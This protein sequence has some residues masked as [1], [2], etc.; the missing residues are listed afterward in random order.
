M[1]ADAMQVYRG[2]DT[3]TA[4]PTLE[5]R[6]RVPHFLVDIADPEEDFSA[7]DYVRAAERALQSV[8]S[9]GLRPMMVGG[10]GLYVRAFLKGLFQGPARVESLRKRL[11]RSA[12]RG[13][14]GHLHRMLAR[15]DPPT[16]ARLMP[17]DSQKI[18]R[19]LE[20]RFATRR[21]L[22]AH[23]TGSFHG[24]WRGCDRFPVVKVGLKMN[25]RMLWERI[26]KRVRTFF[27]QGLVD[28][29]RGL[30]ARGV[31][32]A[33]NAFKGIGYRQCLAVIR[34]R[35][36]E[37][38]AMQRTMVATRQYARRQMTWF[39]REEGTHWLEASADPL[40]TLSSAEALLY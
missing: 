28:E 31:P 12:R 24:D 13:G 8:R 15:L 30:L 25:R 5:D 2:F 29:V 23:L 1:S 27:A 6:E 37:T 39:R 11:R 22:S 40:E 7:G 3:G 34:G 32:E 9:R 10:T 38:E 35:M 20:V 26:E 14:P 17:G 16:A 19:A 33:A 36:N 18:I 21:P 4:K